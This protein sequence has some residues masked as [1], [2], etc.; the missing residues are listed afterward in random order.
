M[1]DNKHPDLIESI[2]FT[3]SKDSNSSDHDSTKIIEEE[4]YEDTSSAKDSRVSALQFNNLDEYLQSK[5]KP[6]SLQINSN[7]FD[8]IE[9]LEE[10]L[11]EVKIECEGNAPEAQKRNE[12][13]FSYY[14]CNLIEGSKQFCDEIH[15][16]K[17]FFKTKYVLSLKLRFNEDLSF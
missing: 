15:K 1:E 5:F 11:L 7:E 16:Y 2:L 9:E 17:E 3:P 8:N 4:S 10:A 12:T 14:L 13:I 6:I